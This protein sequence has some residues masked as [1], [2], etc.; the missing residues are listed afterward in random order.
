MSERKE[1]TITIRLGMQI[2]QFIKRKTI[3][4]PAKIDDRFR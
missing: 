2:A 1:R 3:A 4:A